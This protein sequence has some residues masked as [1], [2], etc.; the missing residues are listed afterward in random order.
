MSRTSCFGA[1]LSLPLLPL[2]GFPTLTA[3]Q[4]A[5]RSCGEVLVTLAHEPRHF[6]GV[7]RVIGSPP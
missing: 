6:H 3:I 1:G 5:S 2:L 4:L 7:A